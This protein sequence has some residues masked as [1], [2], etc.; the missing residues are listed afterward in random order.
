MIRLAVILVFLAL[1]VLADELPVAKI[2]RSQSFETVEA[3]VE[4]T[5]NTLDNHRYEWAGAIFE[6]NE[7]FKSTSPITTGSQH[8]MSYRIR[9]PKNCR[10]VA[11]WH[12][13]PYDPFNKTSFAPSCTDYKIRDQYNLRSFVSIT[14]DMFKELEKTPKH[15]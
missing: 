4:A 14:P 3:A 11:L 6:C 5:L 1:P 10:I 9:K 2:D 12:S 8:E 15:C 7:A 13:H